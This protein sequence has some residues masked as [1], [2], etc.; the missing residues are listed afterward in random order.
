MALVVVASALPPLTRPDLQVAAWMA[1]AVLLLVAPLS[2]LN[3]IARHRHITARTVLGAI[4]IYLQIGV[5]YAGLYRAIDLLNDAA[6][7]GAMPMQPTAYHYFS[8]I[9][10]T[11]VGFGDILPTTNMAR[12]LAY[13]EALIGQVFLVTV[14]A[15]IVAMLGRDRGLD[16]RV[17]RRIA[18]AVQRGELDIEALPE[19][20]ASTLAGDGGGATDV[21]AGET[22]ASGM[23][24]REG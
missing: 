14:V 1:A 20:I 7:S 13:F 19:A 10:L 18:D 3:R 22:R 15:R 16:E 8:F 2:I 6:I 21:T 24:E 4:C 12:T 9:V 11:T 23:T 5:A 17:Q